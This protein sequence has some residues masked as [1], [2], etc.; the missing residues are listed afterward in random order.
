MAVML[1]GFA[2]GFFGTAQADINAILPLVPDWFIEGN[3]ADAS[4]GYSVSEV[5]DINHDG[6]IDFII[7]APYYDHGLTDQGGA[8]AFY[9]SA[10]G[11]SPAP[12]WAVY[13]VKANAEL[14]YSVAGAGDVNNDGFDDVIVGSPG[15]DYMTY[16]DNG[17]VYLYF[18]S[19]DGL[20]SSAS[21][22]RQPNSNASNLRFGKSVSGAGNVNDDA[23]D[24]VIIGGPA[25]YIYHGSDSGLSTNPD[26]TI[27]RSNTSVSWAGDV[28]DDGYDDI[29]YGNGFH[30]NPQLNEGKAVIHLGSATGISATEHWAIESNL[31][32]A[33]YGEFVSA[34]GD[35]NRDGY[36]DVIVGA[37]PRI[38]N[39]TGQ[40]AAYVYYG[41][42]SGV[43]TTPD[44]FY[45]ATPSGT[46]FSSRVTMGGDI[47]GDGIFDVLFG[48]PSY[49]NTQT[50]E[51]SV[52]VFLG[53]ETGPSTT[54][55][56]QIESNQEW[57]NLGWSV[58]GLRDVN[59]DGAG[60]ILVGTQCYSNGEANEGRASL[61]LS[62]PRMFSVFIPAVQR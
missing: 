42:E 37:N 48:A 3:Q 43:D 5:G 46:N 62:L 57:V 59:G 23:Y 54:P 9:G 51:G 27:A 22:F 15:Y 60:D 61:Y 29:I 32:M 7:G 24:D 6:Y 52:L 16:T 1:A 55:D 38:D 4:L 50:D 36:W 56:W 18:G 20:A 49:S 11:F 12:D 47:N 33:K 8:F 39:W 45:M 19:E 58:A 2:A 17:I 30:S 21:Q 31:E 53:S 26:R 41:S 28:N 25:V 14:G 34:T 10:S 13:G 40:S 35:V 44:W